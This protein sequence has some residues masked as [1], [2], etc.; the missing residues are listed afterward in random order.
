VELRRYSADAA[1]AAVVDRGEHSPRRGGNVR[2]SDRADAGT[3]ILGGVEQFVVID[4]IIVIVIVL[5]TVVLGDV[6]GSDKNPRRGIW[7]SWSAWDWKT[8]I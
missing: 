1:I 4:V 5:E 8:V 3:P 7:D 2:R 6:F